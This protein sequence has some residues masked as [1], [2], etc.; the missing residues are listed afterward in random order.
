MCAAACAHTVTNEERLDGMT[1]VTIDSTGEAKELR[2]RETSP[3]VQLARDLKQRKSERLSRF[4]S[5]IAE[6]KSTSSRIDEVFKREPDLLYGPKGDELKHRQVACGEL[7]LAL[8]KERAR[9]ENETEAVAAK[10]EE[11]PAPVVAAP[12]QTET[13]E[14]AA[15]EGFG[16]DADQLR[17]AYKKKAK[18]A[19]AKAKAKKKGKHLSVAAR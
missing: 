18:L 19:K 6:A 14:A 11:K 5:A 16:D 1:D 9:V 13:A 15:D 10:V 4:A 7:A 17:S 3:E 12:K 2:C 8:E